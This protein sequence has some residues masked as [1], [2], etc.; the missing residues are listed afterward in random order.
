[1]SSSDDWQPLVNYR[2]SLLHGEA[3]QAAPVVVKKVY[4]RKGKKNQGG[5]VDDDGDDA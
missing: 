4:G 3:D 2:N 1:M 5:G